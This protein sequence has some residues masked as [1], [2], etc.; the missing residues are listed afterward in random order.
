MISLI[1][2]KVTRNLHYE[3]SNKQAIIDCLHFPYLI[4][5]L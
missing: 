2:A 1:N 5:S 4:Y 3:N